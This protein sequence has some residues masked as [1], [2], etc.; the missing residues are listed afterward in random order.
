MQHSVGLTHANV[1]GSFLSPLCAKVALHNP[2]APLSLKQAMIVPL[3]FTPLSQLSSDWLVL[4][5]R[6]FD[7]V[8]LA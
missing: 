2:H 6:M 1:V 3:L 4:A 8:E 5:N 7:A